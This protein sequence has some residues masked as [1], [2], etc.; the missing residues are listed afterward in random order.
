MLAILFAALADDLRGRLAGRNR[1]RGIHRMHPACSGHVRRV[2]L[3]VIAGRR[4]RRPRF[5]VWKFQVSADDAP[6][7]PGQVHEIH[8]LP[9]AQA[10]QQT[11]RGFDEGVHARHLRA[12]IT[13]QAAQGVPMDAVESELPHRFCPTF[14]H[15]PCPGGIGKISREPRLRRA[16]QMPIPLAFPV[17]Q[18]PQVAFRV[19]ESWFLRANGLH[20]RPR[21]RLADAPRRC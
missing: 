11:V 16:G 4:L 2:H 5:R 1:H 8:G 10:G 19:F 13:G 20:V 15:V 14:D 7:P 21:A 12:V 3:Q 17:A 18:F 6:V 9:Q